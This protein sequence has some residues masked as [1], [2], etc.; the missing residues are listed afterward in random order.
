[1]KNQNLEVDF[2]DVKSTWEKLEKQYEEASSMSG[3]KDN[4]NNRNNNN[5]SD[6]VNHPAHYTFGKYEVIDI[7]KDQLSEE[8]FI[9]YCLGNAVK[10]I[11]R[12]QHKGKF[13]EDLKKSIWYLNKIIETKENN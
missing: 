1:M 12:C 3:R 13:V 5:Q 2:S 6:I 10:Y 4:F 7:I 11:C 8:Q 9:G